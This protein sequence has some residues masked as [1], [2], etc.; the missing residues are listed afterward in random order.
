MVHLDPDFPES[1]LKSSDI[2][3]VP[4]SYTHCSAVVFP[5]FLQLM[6][7]Y[8]IYFTLIFEKRMYFK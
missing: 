2:F 3:P 7:Y 5:G 1:K 8:T 4:I 6:I